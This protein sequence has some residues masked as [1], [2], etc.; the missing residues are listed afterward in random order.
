M[1]SAP[2]AGRLRGAPGAQG[3]ARGRQGPR[4]GAPAVRLPSG[5]PCRL[6]KRPWAV[7]SHPRSY[8]G[9]RTG[10]CGLEAAHVP[11]LK[12]RRVRDTQVW[13]GPVILYCRPGGGPGLGGQRSYFWVGFTTFPTKRG[14]LVFLS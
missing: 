12:H 1:G 9:C 8:G 14:L 5:Q 7:A 10:H 11:R 4:A 6:G 2:A 13:A 3:A